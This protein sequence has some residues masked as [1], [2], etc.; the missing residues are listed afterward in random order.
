MPEKH[1]K[2]EYSKIFNPH[3]LNF[4][5]YPIQKHFYRTFKPF[6]KKVINKEDNAEVRL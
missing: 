3:K 5:T 2:C 4:G 1:Q 6:D